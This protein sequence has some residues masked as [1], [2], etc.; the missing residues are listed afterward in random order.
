[1]EKLIEKIQKLMA[2]AT[3]PNENE[4]KAAS[5]KA[6]ELMIRHNLQ[7]SELEVKPEVGVETFHQADNN[8][9]SFKD[10]LI[11]GIL[12]EYFNVYIIIN[13]SGKG[14]FFG[15][16]FMRPKSL[17]IAG[18]KENIE[19]A[20]YVF[21]YLSIAFDKCWNDYRKAS[22]AKASA[23]KPFYVGL[24]NGFKE[25]LKFSQKACEEKG[26]VVVKDPT[27]KQ[28]FGK[29]SKGQAEKIAQDMEASVAGF[30]AGTKVRVA[31]AVGGNSENSNKLLA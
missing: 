9:I 8:I 25:T 27:L 1:M 21:E 6:H 13:T 10:K 4:A 7:M 20:K 17:K 14:Q 31:R 3:S 19:I 15:N 12:N 23:K 29:L 11:A 16:K 24:A 18:T 26:L 28:Q 22:K 5:A 30:T 2:L